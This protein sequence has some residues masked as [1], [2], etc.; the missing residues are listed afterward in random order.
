MSRAIV[1]AVG[2]VLATSGCSFVFVS[3]PPANHRQLPVVECTTSRIAPG[4]D[5]AWTILQVLNFALAVSR[6]DQEWDDTFGGDPPFSR[7]V[8]VG[9]YTAW[10]LL[11]GAG[12]YF[13]FTRTGA[14]VAA[15]Q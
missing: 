6:T 2:L 8:G 3:G 1:I 4:L 5:A 13:G 9:L 7:S 14:C 15:K 10:A 11:G 12:M